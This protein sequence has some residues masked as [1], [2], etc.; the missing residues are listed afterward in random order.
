MRFQNWILERKWKWEI[1][2][3]GE[4][5]AKGCEGYY[6]GEVVGKEGDEYLILYDDEKEKGRLE[7]ILEDLEKEEWKIG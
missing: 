4:E 7:P 1:E 6:K 5:V 3:W 2:F